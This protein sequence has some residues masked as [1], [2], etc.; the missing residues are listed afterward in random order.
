MAFIGIDLGMSNS[1]AVVLRGGR[2]IIVVNAEGLSIGGKAVP[3]YAACSADGQILI[4]EPARRQAT[5][6]AEETVAA[7][8]RKTGRYEKISLQGQDYVPQQLSAFRLQKIKRDTEAFLGKPM[9]EA[10][11]IV[12]A[13]LDDQRSPAKHACRI[14][15]PEVVR[16][17]NEPTDPRGKFVDADYRKDAVR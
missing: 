13:C 8:K 10:V 2:A 15:V 16:L 17:V 12:L 1:A 9:Q 3:S 4:G 14:A 11:V 5:A 7:F 6:N